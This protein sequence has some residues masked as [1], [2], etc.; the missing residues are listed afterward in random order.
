MHLFRFLV[1]ALVCVVAANAFVSQRNLPR[2]ARTALNKMMG[3]TEESSLDAM[4]T[5]ERA[6][7]LLAQACETR[8]VAPDLLLDSI[9]FLEREQRRRR[10][11]GGGGSGGG[12][13]SGDLERVS[14]CWQ[15]VFTTGDKKT[16]K[17]F[18]RIN[19]FPVKAVQCFDAQTMGI[20]NGIFL[21]DFALLK[22]FGTFTWIDE[23][24]RL[25]FDFDKVAVLGLEFGFG[26]KEPP[27]VPPAFNFIAIEE[28][29]V[30][31]RGAGGGLALWR[32]VG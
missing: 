1:V 17:N 31:A 8:D 13:A 30:V 27:K 10:R 15:L 28:K 18:G 7:A 24:T 19:Y 16:E 12:S 6:N 22:F 2:Q 25:E 29:I 21:G 9:V 23:R 14:G 26:Q 3:Q 11:G 4:L 20:T 5:P 32:R